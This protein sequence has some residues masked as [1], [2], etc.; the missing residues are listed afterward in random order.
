MDLLALV[1][2]SQYLSIVSPSFHFPPSTPSIPDDFLTREVPTA[3]QNDPLHDIDFLEGP[4]CINENVWKPKEYGSAPRKASTRPIRLDS[5]PNGT[6]SMIPT[7]GIRSAHPRSITSAASRTSRTTCRVEIS[8]SARSRHVETSSGSHAD[9][10]PPRAHA[11][12]LRPPISSCTYLPAVNP[13]RQ[14][15]R[16]APSRAARE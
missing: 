14:D 13:S 1:R 11:R 15:E 9:S 2:G 12:S 5:L 10:P 3:R 16:T 4:R 8:P 7:H 6:F